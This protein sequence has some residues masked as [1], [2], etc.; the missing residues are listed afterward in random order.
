MRGLLFLLLTVQIAVAQSGGTPAPSPKP[1]DNWPGFRGPTGDG[2]STAKGVPTTFSEKENVRWKVPIHDKGWSSPV[3]W[4]DQVW[5][6]TAKETG[7]ELFAVCVNLKTGKIEHDLKLFTVKNPPKIAQYNSFASPTPVLE[8][9]RGYFHFGTHGTACLDLKTG[10]LIWKAEDLPLDHWRGPGSSP[11][12]W[13]DSLF[14]TF[15]GH[16]KQF[17]ACLDKKTGVVKWKKDRAIKYPK[18]DGDLKKA[19]STPQVIEVDGKPQVV[20]SAAEA[21][22]AYDPKD[23]KEIWTVYHGGMNEACRPIYAHG[24]VY[25]TAGHARNLLAVK[26]GTGVVPPENVAWKMKDGP[27]RPSPVLVGDHLYVVNDEGT[28]FCVDAKTGKEKWKEKLADKCTASPILVDGNLI[29]CGETG[30]IDVIAADPKEFSRVAT[31]KLDAG[32]KASPAAVGDCL[33]IRTHTHLY[34]IG[35]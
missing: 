1:T 33:L 16:D 15:D 12:V 23:G 3:V 27:T 19:F 26:P 31:N 11:V 32:C 10:K 22:I 8:D 30:K 29:C 35:K 4:G 34:C 17:F 13:G 24:L 18:N 9:G 7:E 25:L 5:L 2:R 20:S 6:T 28:A 21:T 14:L